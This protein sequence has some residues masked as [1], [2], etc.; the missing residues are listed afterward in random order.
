MYHGENGR[1]GFIFS[2]PPCKCTL[3]GGQVSQPDR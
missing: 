1:K 2:L 3:I